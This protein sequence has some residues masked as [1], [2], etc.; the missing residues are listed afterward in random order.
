MMR[1]GFAAMAL[2]LALAA[3]PA[4]AK[5]LVDVADLVETHG[6]AV[7]NIST[8]KLVRQ[9]MDPSTPDEEAMQE[10]FRRFFPGAPGFGGPPMREMPARGAGSGF[11]VSSDGYILTNAHVVRGADEVEV[12]LTDKRKFIAKV[13]GAD[14]RTDVALIRISANGL[15]AVKLGDPNALRVGE[16]VAAIGSPFGFENSVTAGI[17]SAKGR[18][19]PSESY[20]PYIQTDVPINPGNSGGP[21]FNLRGEV[22]GINSQIYSRSGGYQ[23]VSFAIPIDVAMD[24]A[25]QL[26]QSG[27]VSRGW[28]GVGIQEVTADLAESFGLDRPRGALV[29]QVQ[30]DSP[31]A[32][33][34]LQNADVILQFNGQAVESSGDLPRLVGMAKPGSRATLRVWRKGRMQDVSVVLGELPGE[35]QPVARN[36]KSYSKGGLVLSELSAEQRR[37]LGIDAGLLVEEVTGDAARAG[38]RVGDVILAVNNARASSVDAFRKAIAAIPKGKS[39]AVLVRRGEGSLYIPLKIS[40]G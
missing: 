18:S 11:I 37:E 30:P 29:S 32:K 2:G 8:T 27:K 15:P 34:G 16:A 5:T 28:L 26:R 21:L 13:V 19:L 24:V 35:D 10:F 23:G 25:E 14:S 39:A 3:T 38:I 20:V 33:A 31:A 4:A 1:N 36:G 40:G 7:V 17:V 12:K 9:G 6:P 22:I